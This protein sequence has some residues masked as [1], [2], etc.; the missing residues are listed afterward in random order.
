MAG[1]LKHKNIDEINNIGILAAIFLI[2]TFF[3]VGVDIGSKFFLLEIISPVILVLMIVS[4]IYSGKRLLIKTHKIYFAAIFIL[5]IWAII[6]WFRYPLSGSIGM[7]SGEGDVGIKSYLRIATGFCTFFITFWYVYHKQNFNYIAILKI[8][9]AFSLLIGLVRIV[10]YFLHFDIPLMYG[11]FRYNPEAS[12]RYGGTAYRLSG[13]DLA[14]YCG[15]F[16]LIALRNTKKAPSGI[17]FISLLAIFTMYMFINAGRA[18]TIGYL[19]ALFYYFTMVEKFDIRKIIAVVALIFVLIGSIQFLPEQMVVGQLSRITAIQGGIQGQYASRRGVIFKA[20]LEEFY[21]K[22]I[23]GRGIRPV[24][25]DQTNRN[26]EWIQ[27]Q[28]A[29]GGHGSYHSILGVFGL[30]G[31]FFLAVFLFLPIIQS[32]FKLNS[33]YLAYRPIYIFIILNLLSKSLVFYAGGKGYNDY[34]LYMLTAIF[35]AISAKKY[36][37]VRLEA[38]INPESDNQT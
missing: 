9:I 32:H 6:S 11:S 17:V 15:A 7:G 8:L 34:T 23:F 30:G 1:L 20:F 31:F 36:H 4:L 2:A 14:G 28:L 16:S 38:T 13:L 26:T 24:S 21:K 18:S 27:N 33:K 5:V 10:S 3:P 22:P 29:D 37:I 25:I 35:I 12:G 19:F